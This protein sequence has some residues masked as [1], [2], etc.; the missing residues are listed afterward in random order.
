MRNL[1]FFLRLF[2]WF[3]MR[4]MRAHPWRVFAVLLGIALGAGVFT[5]VRLAVHASLTSFEKSMDVLSGK[6]DRVVVQ[7][8]G[9]VPERLVALLKGHPAVEAA[10]PL[11]TV[12]VQSGPPCRSSP[13]P[14]D[15]ST[16]ST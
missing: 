5:S 6:A 14:R 11:T 7:P 15:S 9:R 2:V 12:Y 13:V 4:S 8:G 16:V 1:T 10:S 3:G